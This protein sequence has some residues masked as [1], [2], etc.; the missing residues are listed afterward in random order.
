MASIYQPGLYAFVI[1]V[2]DPK[3]QVDPLVIR[4]NVT[5]DRPMSDAEIAQVIFTAAA[6]NHPSVPVLRLSRP[7]YKLVLKRR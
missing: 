5:V 2:S 4:S 6:A 1:R 7:E 3:G